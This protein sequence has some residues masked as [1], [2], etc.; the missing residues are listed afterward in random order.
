MPTPSATH[1]VLVVAAERCL[2]IA[3]RRAARTATAI[4]RAN[5]IEPVSCASLK[6]ALARRQ[7]RSAAVAL[8]FM[9]GSTRE[10]TD[11]IEALL[12]QDR[13][14]RVV[15]ITPAID[16]WQVRSA[17]A[18]GARGVL[19]QDEELPRSLPSCI[20]SVLA[21]QVCVPARHGR[22]VAPPALSTREKQ[23]LGL[24]AMGYMNSQIA[25]RLFL[26]ESTVKSH[27]SSAFGKL[28]VRSRNEAVRLIVD[29]SRGIGVGILTLPSEPI[30]L[31]FAAAR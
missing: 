20:R 8:L 16:R 26:A 5:R 28:G 23:I 9:E 1:E 13:N 31:R 11:A 21:G 18:A 7:V 3:E 4:L 24:V 14:R 2:L 12:A 10:I 27:L 25:T 6:Q 15:L 29:P 30:D 19:L 22:Q 17:L